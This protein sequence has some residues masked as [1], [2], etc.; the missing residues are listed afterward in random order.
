MH[1]KPW[2][3]GLPSGPFQCN[4]R[5]E[6]HET[7]LLLLDQDFCPNAVKTTIWGITNATKVDHI[8]QKCCQDTMAAA[9]MHTAQAPKTSLD[10]DTVKRF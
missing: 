5:S 1:G 2:P 4:G 8:V 10:N 7:T 9:N 6:L 3:T